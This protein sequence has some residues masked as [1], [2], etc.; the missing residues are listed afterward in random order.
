MERMKIMSSQDRKEAAA[1]VGIDWA[2]ERH[3]VSLLA[4]EA[5]ASVER[6]TLE[7]TPEAIAAWAE[8]LRAR[9][10][11]RPVAVAVEQKRGALLAALAGHS[12]LKI[13]PVN[14]LSAARFRQAMFPSGAK[15]DPRDSDLLLEFLRLHGERL[16]PLFVP[17]ELTRLAAQMAEDR[18]KCVDERTALIESAQARLKEYFP[19]ALAAAGSLSCP[20]GPA[21]LLRWPTLALAQA[22]R[23]CALRAFFYGRNARAKVEERIQALKAARPLTEDAALIEA[24]RRRVETLCALIASL[25][26]AIQEYDARIAEVFKSHPDCEIFDSLP[27]GPVMKPRVLAAFGLDRGRYKSALDL[28]CLSGIAP[29]QKSSGKATSVEARRACPKHLRQTFHEFAGVTLLKKGWPRAYY[30]WKRLQGKGHHD[31][32]R[33][34]AGKWQRV[35]FACWQQSQPYDEAIYLKQLRAKKAPYLHL[36]PE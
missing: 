25:T 3:A 35:L 9:F 29:V 20:M 13:Y 23:P 28:Q 22:A 2:D 24:G 33:S 15:S 8:G 17:D 1:W 27:A 30:E 18:R 4:A 11:G 36:I 10:Q 32:V 7:Q 16:R 14:P 12:F 34:L 21:F 19:A 5:G 26:E 6:G 31:A